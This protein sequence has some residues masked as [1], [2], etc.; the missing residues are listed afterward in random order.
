MRPSAF[1]RALRLNSGYAEVHNNLGIAL[2][3]KG[4]LKDAEAHFKEAL[5]IRPGFMGARNNLKKIL[6]ARVK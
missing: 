5:L 1:S 4:K 3:R 6:A 2:A